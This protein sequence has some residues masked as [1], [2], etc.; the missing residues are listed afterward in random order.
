MKFF[1]N[2]G[3]E[4]VGGQGAPNLRIDRV[5]AVAQKILDTQVLFEPFE[6]NFNC[7][8]LLYNVAMVKG[9]KLVVLVKKTKVCWVWDL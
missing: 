8:R 6:N 3:D 7:Q 9:G 1:L 2:N 4:H 5:L